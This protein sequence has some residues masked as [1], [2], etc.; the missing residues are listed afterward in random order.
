MT[1]YIETKVWDI[2]RCASLSA[3]NPDISKKMTAT[4]SNTKD[5]FVY[6]SHFILCTTYRFLVFVKDAT[7]IIRWLF[8]DLFRCASL[9]TLTLKTFIKN[10]QRPVSTQQINCLNFNLSDTYTIH[11]FVS[12]DKLCK[13]Q[14]LGHFQMRI[15]I[16]FNIE[17]ISKKPTAAC[18]NT[19]DQLS[20]FICQIHRH[21]FN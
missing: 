10:W 12:D 1:N 20:I 18:F 15:I 6:A 3:L 11:L 8:R 21:Y 7:T 5:C 4:C 16:S 14:S 13:N 19:T 9:S 17:D 2:F